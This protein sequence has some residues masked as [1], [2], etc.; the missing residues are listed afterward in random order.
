MSR[1]SGDGSR[2]G[3]RGDCT[4]PCRLAY[5]LVEIGGPDDPSGD[6][7]NPGGS[8]ASGGE[9][10]L[11]RGKH[12]LSMRD[13]DLSARL[14]ELLDAG[15]SSFKIEGR[16]KDAAY[17]RNVVSHYRR[18][19]DK[20]LAGRPG[21]RRASV[22]RSEPDFT[23]DPAKS[24]TRGNGGTE[25]FLD[26]PRRGVGSLHTPKAMGES[27]GT[28]D[29]T[30][31]ERTG[32]RFFT[33]RGP[34]AMLAAGDGICFFASGVMRG[35][36]INRVEGPRIYPDKGDDIASGTEIFRN[37]D[38]SFVR[39]LER[40][41]MKRRIAV[42]ARLSVSPS[43]VEVVFTDE[44][45]LSAAARCDG[46]FEPAR[47]VAK[48]SA[49]IREQLARDGDTIFEV[50]G[51]SIEASAG[52]G[53]E[54]ASAALFVP[55]STLARL[56]REGLERL[57]EARM[58]L[59]PRRSPAVENSTEP[60]PR[61]RLAS[62]ENVTN[63]LAERFWR[64]HGVTEIAPALELTGTTEGSDETAAVTEEAPAM[65]TRYCIRR[66]IGECLRENPG[67]HEN[68]RPHGELQIVHGATR[69][70]LDFDCEKCE[71]AITIAANLHTPPKIN[72]R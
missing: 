24:F 14:G 53:N 72:Q 58:A 69:W 27:V 67:P 51:V 59:P 34:S 55:V 63:R 64:D 54:S 44:T 35:T 33:L 60:F 47:D 32:N 10:I 28:V 43:V 16:L 9:R 39:A 12:L 37:Y 49:T 8:G 22:G 36:N 50:T 19:L 11:M 17:V 41:R 71:M 13:L 5:D 30:G 29:R 46:V 4:Q 45:G 26:G 61:T 15:V 40:S 66:E 6:T 3:N 18:R 56:R 42:A 57:L 62:T 2:S 70:R 21:L 65:R 1:L 23:P 68:S 52:A 25:Y 31:C 7:D 38:H 48:M 20:A